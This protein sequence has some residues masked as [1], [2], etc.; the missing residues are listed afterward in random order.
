LTLR[1]AVGV[2]SP[3]AVFKEFGFDISDLV[4]LN[5]NLEMLGIRIYEYSDE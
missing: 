3:A 4:S 5:V 2:L 1:D